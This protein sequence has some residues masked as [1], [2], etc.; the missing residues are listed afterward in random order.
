MPSMANDGP[1]DSIESAHD[2]MNLL[3]ETI[4]IAITDLHRDHQIALREDQ[5]RRARAIELALFKAKTLNCYVNKSRRTLNDL[6]TI[7]RLILN[8]RMSPEAVLS[9]I[10]TL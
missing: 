3:A 6:R 8:E 5:P 4:M 9:S 1:F 2:F 7:R 10:Q